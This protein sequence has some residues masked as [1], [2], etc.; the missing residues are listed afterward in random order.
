MVLGWGPGD[1]DGLGDG[2][3]EGRGEADGPGDA[4]GPAEGDVLGA[5]EALWLGHGTGVDPIGKT[6]LGVVHGVGLGDGEALGEGLGEALA[7]ALAGG[8]LAGGGVV[9][10]G[11]RPTAAVTAALPIE[12]PCGVQI[13]GP[14]Q[15]VSCGFGVGGVAHSLSV[16]E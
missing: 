11:G 4:E 5:G 16:G 8:E 9:V 10:T 13:G 6:G 12:G 7:D 2:E 1:E 3:A 15:I 14:G